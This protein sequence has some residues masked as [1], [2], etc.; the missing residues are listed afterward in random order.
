MD[1]TGSCDVALAACGSYDAPEVGGALRTALERVGGLSF[2]RAGMRVAVKVNLVTAMKPET[3]ATVHPAVVCA[4]VKLLRE[5]GAEVVIG[6]SPGGV[7]SAPYLRV[8]YDVCG[9]RTAEACGAKLNDDF[10]VTE[11]EDPEAVAAKR[12][13]ATAYLNKADAIIDLC[14]LKTHGMMGLTCAV[15]NFFGAIPG[16]MKPE[17]HYKYPRAEDFAD[18]LV[19]L[20]EH[21]KPRLCICDAVVAMEGN[22]PTQGSPRA[23]GCLI[24]SRNGHFLDAVA[25]GLIALKPEEVPT[26]RAAA[27][28][29]LLPAELSA[30]S[31]SGDPG[32]FKVADFKTVPAQSSVF[33]HVLGD[34]PLGKVADFVAARILTP[35]PKLAP[36]SCVGCGKCAQICPA[37]AIAMQKGK[38]RI[39]R[40]TCIHCFCCQE[41]CPRGAIRVGR[42][43]IMRLL[44]RGGAD[45]Q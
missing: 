10:S 22:G 4:L 18:M 12:F 33:F 39:D 31:V 32:Q 21:F 42:T 11:V 8:V 40:K 26:L 35:F 3:A 36:T 15:K 20:Y 28:R 16:T 7:Y 30:I 9:M 45:K 6:D 24:A 25:A 43:R 41:F 38:P 2:V 29:G 1:E 44:G 23:V 17:Y 13:T 19:D 37:K 34:G 5:R 14:K 27:R